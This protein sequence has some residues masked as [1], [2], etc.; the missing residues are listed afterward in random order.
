MP[1][2]PVAPGAA[3]MVYPFA[4]EV[5]VIFVPSIN[6]AVFASMVSIAES[7]SFPEWEYSAYFA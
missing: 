6:E 2:G 4:P 7:I 1:P 3:E 5:I